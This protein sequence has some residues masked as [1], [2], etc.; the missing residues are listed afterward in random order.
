MTSA[1][2]WLATRV[3]PD[4]RFIGV[5]PLTYGRARLGVSPSRDV[6]YFTDQW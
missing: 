5:Y 1:D 4:G 6:D 3:L 2:G